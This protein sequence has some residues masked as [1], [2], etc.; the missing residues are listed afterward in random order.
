MDFFDDILG[1][2]IPIII[3][4]MIFR[5]LLQVILGGKR[6]PQPS[7]EEPTEYD[8]DGNPVKWEQETEEDEDEEE[9]APES[10]KTEEQLILEEFERAMRRP[11][12]PPVYT[13]ETAP[14]GTTSKEE[15]KVIRD[16]DTKVFRDDSDKV[17]HDEQV[18]VH[19]D[20]EPYHHGKGAILT[21][22]GDYEQDNSKIYREKPLIEQE[23]V[24]PVTIAQDA[25]PKRVQAKQPKLLNAIKWMEILGKPKSM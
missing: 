22:A 1:R 12:E 2:I 5:N 20:D 14:R 8:Q 25:E 23:P 4:F 17:V 16:E 6:P 18:V 19:R 15:Q 9:S 10:G 3:V 7:E 13:P 24:V 21:D 11:K